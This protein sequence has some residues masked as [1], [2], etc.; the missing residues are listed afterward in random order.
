MAN[1]L[2]TQVLL[3]TKLREEIERARRAHGESMAEYLRKAVQERL[4]R[5]QKRHTEYRKLAQEVVGVVRDSSWKNTDVMK[6][7]KEMRKDR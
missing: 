6:W 7:Q 2:R 4:E 5:E 1:S 3:P